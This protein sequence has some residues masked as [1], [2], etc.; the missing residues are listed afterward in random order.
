M[1]QIS[2]F[3]FPINKH[4]K[5]CL[6][7][8]LK[9]A[10]FEYALWAFQKWSCIFTLFY[11]VNT[12]SY[13]LEMTEILLKGHKTL[14]HPSKY[15]KLSPACQCRN[16]IYH[17]YSNKCPLSNKKPLNLLSGGSHQ[18]WLEDTWISYT[19]LTQETSYLGTV[20]CKDIWINTVDF[21]KIS[22]K[23]M[24]RDVTKPTKWLCTQRRLRSAQSDQ[25]LCCPHEES[26]GP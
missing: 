13:R 22:P 11:A 10:F 2:Y 21:L 24:S 14:T 6:V 16:L 1:L 23:Y 9:A 5:D 20:N 26:L 19:R 4:R 8:I 17:I 7:K 25:S 12:G 18:Y 15:W 3:D